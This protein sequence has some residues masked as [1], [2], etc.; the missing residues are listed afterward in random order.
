MSAV[1]HVARVY[2]S[3]P[4]YPA[5]TFL[6]DRL[7]PRGISKAR[8]EGVAWLKTVAPSSDL[9]HAFHEQRVSWDE[10]GVLYRAELDANDARDALLAILKRGEPLTLL[11]GSRDE[12]HNQAIVLREYL[13]ERV[14][15]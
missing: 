3:H 13:L 4:P 15:S 9:R 5:N 1:I 12:Q 6:T 11:Y 2:D 7:W 14:K 8:L 10:F